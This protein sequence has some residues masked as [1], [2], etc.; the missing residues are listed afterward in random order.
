MA[1]EMGWRDTAWIA[2]LTILVA[3]SISFAGR[4]LFFL[5]A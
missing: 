1:K 2:G 5:A 4:A 3:T